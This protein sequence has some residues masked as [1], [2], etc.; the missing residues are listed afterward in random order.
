MRIAYLTPYPP[1]MMPPEE[2]A[3]WLWLVRSSHDSAMLQ[4]DALADL[5][6]FDVIWW[7][8]T[9]R[10][11][12]HSVAMT[13]GC[14]DALNRYV[15]GGGS[16]LLTLMA[17]EYVHALGIESAPPDRIEIGRWE[18]ESIMAAYPDMRGFH[19]W[20]RHPLFDGLH[21]GVYTWLPQSGE[22]FS[23]TVYS[24]G[25]DPVEGKVLAL[26]R[27]RIAIVEDCKCII[28][29]HPGDGKA[30]TI[31]THLYFAP[32]LTEFEKHRDRFMENV[33][34]ELTVPDGLT[35]PGFTYFLR[36]SA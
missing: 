12:D 11:H 25:H 13:Q 3:A 27:A 24:K 17:A 7:H 19:G 30:L 26:E 6:R 2:Q 29:Y 33:F 31:G 16:L 20:L 32:K 1:N 9:T 22:S 4:F 28:S 34:T 8:A 15:K 21:G 14:T 5:V 35:A 36:E 23:R 10:I 18:T